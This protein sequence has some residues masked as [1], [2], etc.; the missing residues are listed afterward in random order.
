MFIHLILKFLRIYFTL[1]FLTRAQLVTL[2]REELVEELIKCSNIA[3]QLKTFSDRFGVFVDKYKMLQSELVIS[4]NF[5]FLLV[6]RIINLERNALSNAQYRRREMLEINPILHSINNADLPEKACEALSL[7][8]TKVERED[9]DACYKMK[10]KDKAIFKFKNR[11]QR[12]GMIFK[13][14]ELKS[15]GHDLVALQFAR[16]LFINDSMCFENQVLFHECQ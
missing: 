4:K 11:K 5:N 12:N 13:G 14:K 1:R 9:L 10:K 2:S 8:G 16:S 7:T 15:K 3:D 6:N